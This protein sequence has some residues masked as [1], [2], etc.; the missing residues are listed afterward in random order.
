MTDTTLAIQLFLAGKRAKGLAPKTLESYRY[1]LGVYERTHPTLPTAPDTIEQ[2]LANVGPSLENRE[3]Y[4]RLLRNFYNV[5]TKK[6]VVISNPV[7]NLEAPV[8][9]RKVAR[10][11]TPS[12]LA[13]LLS[14]PSHSTQMSAYLHLLADTGLRLSEALSVTAQDFGEWT[15]KVSGK[16][17]EREVPISPAILGMVLG[18]LPWPWSSGQAAGLA[19]RKAFRAAGFT[20][21]RAS[22]HSLRHTF[23]RLW[24]GDETLLQGILGWTSL[25]MLKVYRPYHLHRAIEQHHQYSP[26]RQAQKASTYQ[27]TFL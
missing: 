25:R 15:V 24:E 6:Q 23:V 22:A 14:W 18:A 19:V 26:L 20:G 1:R 4:Y 3:T 27:A 10:S 16:V 17:G 12:E 2:F 21:K 13:R 5:L 7:L 9:R 11:L 8:L